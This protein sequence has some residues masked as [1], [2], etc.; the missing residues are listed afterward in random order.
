MIYN[1]VLY[2]DRQYKINVCVSDHFE[3]IHIVL[4]NAVT[5]KVIYDNA[6]EEYLGTLTL[7]IEHT[8]RLKVSLEVLA[9]DMTEQ[10]KLD[11]FG[12]IGMM[13]QYKKERN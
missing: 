11:Y 2:A 5:D 7:N 3:P 9:E 13:I 12:C 6:K 4:M 8:Q 10:E 1:L